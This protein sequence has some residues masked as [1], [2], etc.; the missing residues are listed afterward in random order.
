MNMN[1]E[2]I[3]NVRDREEIRQSFSALSKITFGLDFEP[4]YLNGYWSDRYVPY[5]IVIDGQ[6]VANVSANIMNFDMY[7]VSKRLIQIGTVMTSE[8]Y[9]GRGFTKLL[10][11]EVEKDF[12]ANVDGFYLF[13]NDSVVDF[14]PKFGYTKADEYFYSKDLSA[15]DTRQISPPQT[16][17]NLNMN[18]TSH[19]DRVIEAMG[20]SASN[21]AFHMFDNDGLILFYLTQFM[22]EN[23]YYIASEDTYVV[24]ETDEGTLILHHVFSKSPCRLNEI[25]AAF[26]PA[27]RRVVLGFTPLDTADFNGSLLKEDDTTLFVKGNAFDGFSGKH[28]RFPTL[29]Q[30]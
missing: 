4:W 2:I 9:R 3:K 27:A 19:R 8:K 14:Y 18:V 16:A 26:G 15:S 13:A 21:S 20:N 29:S 17:E 5:A 11:Q 10:M 22:Q 24:A 1:L 30:A 12:S 7:G 25:I 28:L 23:V 6:V